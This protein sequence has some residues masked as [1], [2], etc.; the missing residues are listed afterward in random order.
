MLQVRQKNK[1]RN[2]KNRRHLK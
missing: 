2:L 1:S